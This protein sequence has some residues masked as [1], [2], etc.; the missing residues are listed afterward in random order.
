MPSALRVVCGVQSPE[1]GHG[2][3]PILL[4]QNAPHIVYR[5]YDNVSMQVRLFLATRA[6]AAK[7]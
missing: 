6:E 4:Q 7:A 2:I 5:K 1:V 3:K